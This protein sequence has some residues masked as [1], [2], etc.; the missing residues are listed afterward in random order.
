DLSVL[1]G[2]SPARS[3]GSQGEQRCLALA[4]KMGIH[5]IISE[6]SKLAGGEGPILILDDVFSELDPARSDALA[7]SLPSGQVLVSA[8]S[9][10]PDS[11][12][13]SHRIQV[14]A[15]TASESEL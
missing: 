15:G 5:R 6:K 14:M 4:L 2:G 7:R 3:F 13:P 8:A 11:L 9:G 1:L 10:V 12:V